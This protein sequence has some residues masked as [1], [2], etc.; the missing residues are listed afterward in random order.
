MFNDWMLERLKEQNWN[1][2]DLA[3]ASGLTRTAVSNYINGRIPDEAALRKLAKG[4]KLPPETVFR[5][6]GILPPES[7]KTP[8]LL[9]WIGIFTEA[10]DNDRQEMLNYARYM[11]NRKTKRTSF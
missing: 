4:F 5:A 6:A 8:N 2:A 10:D 1:Q 11:S 7:E 3:R 9:E